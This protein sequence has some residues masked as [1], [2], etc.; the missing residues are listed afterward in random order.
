MAL[1]GHQ[2]ARVGDTVLERPRDLLAEEEENGDVSLVRDAH[3]RHGAALAHLVDVEAAA[4][5]GLAEGDV[6]GCGAL[7]LGLALD[8]RPE[9]ERLVGLPRGERHA[10]EEVGDGTGNDG[11]GISHG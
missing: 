1:P 11:L 9:A 10:G 2:E 8:E 5:E 4:G 7:G 3:H 6:G